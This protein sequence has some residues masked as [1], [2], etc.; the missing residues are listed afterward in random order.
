MI[1]ST[2]HPLT[3][4]TERHDGVP[5]SVPDVDAVPGEVLQR[6]DLPRPRQPR[7]LRLEAG[8][9]QPRGREVGEASEHAHAGYLEQH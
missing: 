7:N 6:V 8:A 5:L 3:S 4:L 2:I 9:G 1:Q